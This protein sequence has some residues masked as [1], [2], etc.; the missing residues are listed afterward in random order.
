MDN[1]GRIKV[2]YDFSNRLDIAKIKDD[3][4]YVYFERKQKEAFLIRSGEYELSKQE[5]DELT[6]IGVLTKVITDDDIQKIKA[7]ERSM[8]DGTEE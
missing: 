7:I 6:G 3:K 1:D 4:I 2:Y 5:P 8:P